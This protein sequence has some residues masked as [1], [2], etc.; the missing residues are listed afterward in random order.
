M[1]ELE[2]IREQRDKVIGRDTSR[3]FPEDANQENGNYDNFC[4]A[5]GVKFIGNKHRVTCKKC[6]RTTE[7]V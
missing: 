5:C 3:D 4:S 7:E 1:T 2:T 6:T